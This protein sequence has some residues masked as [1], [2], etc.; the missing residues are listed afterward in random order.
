MITVS[1]MVSVTKN[2]VS[3]LALG[4][5]WVSVIMAAA[6][7]DSSLFCTSRRAVNALSASC[8]G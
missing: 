3:E 1:G 6:R 5:S 4:M 2:S 7:C 8:R